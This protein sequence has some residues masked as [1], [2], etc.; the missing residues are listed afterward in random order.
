MIKNRKKSERVKFVKYLPLKQL[1]TE[2]E[3]DITNTFVSIS[4]ADFF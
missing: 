3:M 2:I 4:L 1:L